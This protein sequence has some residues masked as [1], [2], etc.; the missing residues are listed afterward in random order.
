MPFRTPAAFFGRVS[1]QRAAQRLGTMALA[2]LRRASLRFAR[3]LKVDIVSSRLAT[4][5]MKND[6]NPKELTDSD[7]LSRN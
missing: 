5:A 7:F 1:P 2:A 3:A 6:G 4:K